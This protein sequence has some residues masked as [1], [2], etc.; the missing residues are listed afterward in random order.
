L[1]SSVL[2][3]HP[4]IVTLLGHAVDHTCGDALHRPVLIFEKLSGGSLGEMLARRSLLSRY[5]IP[6]LRCLQILRDLSSAIKYLHRDYNEEIRILHRDLKPDNIWS[7][8]S[9]LSLLIL[10]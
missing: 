8:S 7:V 9:I 1:S 6:F 10:S 5:P 2:V 3:S 4:N